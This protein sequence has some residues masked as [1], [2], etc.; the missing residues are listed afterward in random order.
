[1]DAK[2]ETYAGLFL[3]ALSTLMYEII[4]TRIFSIT[5]WY[6]F[7]FLVISLAM[8]GMTAGAIIVYLMRA[9]LTDENTHRY[10]ALSALSFSIISI[11]AVLLHIATPLFVPLDARTIMVTSLLVVALPLLCAFVAS[12]VCVSLALTRFPKQLHK[13]Y[14][15]DLVG[16]ALGCIAIV[17]SLQLLDGM[18]DLFLIGCIASLS[19]FF[20]SLGVPE[21]K[22]RSACLLS[23]VLLG[24]ITGVNGYSAS[25]QHPIVWV[26]WSKGVQAPHVVY[27]KWN[28]FSRIR[29]FGDPNEVKDLEEFGLSHSYRNH[30]GKYLSLD[31]DGFAGTHLYQTD[32]DLGGMD[33]LKHDVAELAHSLKPHSD[34]MIMG[35]GGGKD[36]LGALLL[37][38][39]SITGVEINDNTINVLSSVYGDYTGHIDRHPGV[40]LIN[41]E[42]RSFLTRSNRKFDVIQATLV[43]TWAAS[44]SGAYSLTENSL[45]TTD[46]WAIFLNHLNDGGMLSMSRWY[47]KN[48]P[49]EI[50]RLVVLAAE[51]LKKIGISD[52]VDHIALVRLQNPVVDQP[53][54]LGT[55]LVSKTKF[56]SAELDALEAKCKADGFEI[57]LSPRE[58]HD[59]NLK[60]AVNED[61]SELSQHVPFD[62]TAS[63]DDRPFFFQNLSLSHI[64]DPRVYEESRN[65]NNVMA[66]ISLIVAMI[67]VSFFF[68][69]CIR[70][71][72][73]MTK[74]RSVL[75]ETKSLFVYF[76]SIGLGFMLVELSQIQRFNITLGHPI[77]AISVVLFT[78]L[79]GTGI[80]SMLFEKVL[81][82]VKGN[83]TSVIVVLL[84]VAIGFGLVT[85]LVTTAFAGASTPVRIFMS[86]VVLLPLGM[87][88]G[89]AFPLGMRLAFASDHAAVTPWLWGIN[90][91]ASVFGSVLATLISMF[92][93]ISTTYWVGVGFYIIT[94]LACAP[95][96]AGIP[97]KMELLGSPSVQPD[98]SHS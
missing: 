48:M 41:D 18:S 84:V 21:P 37:K 55:I 31:M 36:I 19:A 27:E 1:M 72:L 71:P 9:K 8:L 89:L 74:D 35:V 80:G 43:D 14:A 16:A 88:L 81:A 96:S 54:G 33:F 5:T 63:T 78:L 83:P 24:V 93:G 29:V 30:M 10:L 3:I 15:F 7:A 23:A 85:P 92:V 11:L 47:G 40:A 46:A 75:K 20:F 22:I 86:G 66:S 44:S 38:Q 91:A 49:A 13:L 28:C 95:V 39:T 50:Y 58:C 12:G 60:L 98:A 90:G 79:L 82:A 97:G 26:S 25:Q 53:D 56:T 73:L 68:I 2:R 6:H 45:Y 65:A 34:V 69:Y 57:M 87:V 59:P 52:P 17:V 64:F 70:L 4:L 61:I 77:Y 76:A 67:A 94:A 32:N 51:S 62:V 42:A